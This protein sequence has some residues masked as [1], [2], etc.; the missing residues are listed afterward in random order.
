MDANVI[1]SQYMQI[2]YV[3]HMTYVSLCHTPKTNILF[4]VNYISIKK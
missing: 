4:Y 3:I 1:I 2:S